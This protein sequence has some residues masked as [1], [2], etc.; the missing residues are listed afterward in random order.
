MRGTVAG[1]P[2]EW[3]TTDQ[4][5]AKHR[6]WRRDAITR[7]RDGVR[8]AE[9]GRVDPDRDREAGDRQ[10]EETGASTEETHGADGV[11]FH[12]ARVEHPTQSSRSD[13]PDRTH[14]LP[15]HL[16]THPHPARP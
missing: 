4:R 9:D 5:D 8:H 14:H 12:A 1:R 2:A 11:V 7:K 16:L 10:A 15:C 13:D 6:V 3:P